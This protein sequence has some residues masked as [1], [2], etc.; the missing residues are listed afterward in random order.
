MPSDPL[1]P[2]ARRL[3]DVLAGAGMR[4]TYIEQEGVVHT[5]PQQ[6][7][8]PEGQ[9]TIHDHV[10]WIGDLLAGRLDGPDCQTPAG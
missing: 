1:L 2:D 3:R 5:Y 8:T 9:W 7:T 4:V 6:V 10:H